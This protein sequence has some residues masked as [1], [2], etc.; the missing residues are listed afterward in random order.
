MNK[1]A[2]FR[3]YSQTRKQSQ[4]A[5]YDEIFFKYESGK[6]INFKL[7]SIFSLKIMGLI[8]S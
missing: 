8:C 2:N 7:I 3:E 6:K 4:I 1:A 5:H